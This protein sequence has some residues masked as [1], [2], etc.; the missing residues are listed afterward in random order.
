MD[1]S[2]IALENYLTELREQGHDY[3]YIE[4]VRDGYWLT[5][6][7]KYYEEDENE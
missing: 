3:S 2:E 6:D 7:E 1:E 5:I 4:G